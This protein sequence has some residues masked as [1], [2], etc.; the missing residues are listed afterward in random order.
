MAYSLYKDYVVMYFLRLHLSPHCAVVLKKRPKDLKPILGTS[1]I[2][3]FFLALIHP[4]S[5]VAAIEVARSVSLK[6]Q[7]QTYLS[8]FNPEPNLQNISR[9]PTTRST[10]LSYA[11]C[12]SRQI[13]LAQCH[14]LVFANLSGVVYYLFL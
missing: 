4:Y 14:L 10:K 1:L 2:P 12:L 13:S 11:A 8:F 6:I 5:E 7:L 9:V 3:S